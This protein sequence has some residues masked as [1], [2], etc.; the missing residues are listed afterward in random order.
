MQPK[1]NATAAIAL[2]YNAKTATTVMTEIA[3]KIP[4]NIAVRTALTAQR[5]ET[6]GLPAIA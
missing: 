3:K 2:R 1:S 4:P 5:P 6:D